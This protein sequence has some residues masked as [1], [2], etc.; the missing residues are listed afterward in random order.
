MRSVR[1]VIAALL[2]AFVVWPSFHSDAA[3]QPGPIDGAAALPR[4]EISVDVQAAERRMRVSGTMTFRLPGEG[5]VELSVTRLATDLSVQRVDPEAGRTAIEIPVL[6]SGDAA[7]RLRVPRPAGQQSM[8]LAFSYNL[9]GGPAP[10]Y[11]VGPEVVVA[12]GYGTDWYPVIDGADRM[13]GTLDFRVP[14]GHRVVSEGVSQASPAEEAQGRFRFSESRPTYF[15]FL[16]GR[17]TATARPGPV[18]VRAYLLREHGGTDA[19]LEGVQAITGVLQEEFGSFPFPELKLIE[20]PRE[21]AQQAGFNAFAARGILVLNHRAFDVPNI[22]VLYEWLGH[23]IGHQWFPHAVAL[24]TPPGLYM[25]EALAEYGGLR[26]VERLAGAPAAEQFRRAGYSP[27]PVYGARQYFDLV[28]AGCDRPL[29]RLP[30]GLASRNVAYNKGFLA[31][32][33]LAAEMGR[34]QFRAAMARITRERRFGQIGWQ[35]FLG[36]IQRGTPR[37]LAPFFEQWF[38]RTGLPDWTVEWSQRGEIVRGR[39][40]QAEP[41]Y[42]ATLELELRGRGEGQAR[43]HRLALRPARET[44]FSLSTPFPVAS[45]VADPHYHVPHWTE[46][47]RAQ[48]RA[49]GTAGSAA[50]N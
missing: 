45:V 18:P 7:Y 10:L 11:Y 5:P 32:N 36:E 22:S 34:A 29:A 14:P 39:V 3:F 50:C 38:E 24:R 30:R 44:S 27:D 26:V 6:N 2:T 15:T 13:T 23:E 33:A 16:A 28:A 8:T 41:Y 31:W 49:A 35:E 19:Y 37:P 25:E 9:R 1:A 12:S 42:R 46:D 47:Y 21:I 4:Y 17:F 48:V 43:S 40:I 20:I